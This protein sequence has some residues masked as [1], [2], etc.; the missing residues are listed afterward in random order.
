MTAPDDLKP[1]VHSVPF[2]HCHECGAYYCLPCG[3]GS[4][5]ITAEKELAAKDAKIAQ[6]DERIRQLTGLK[7]SERMYEAIKSRM[8]VTEGNMKAAQD[9]INWFLLE[10]DRLTGL[11]S[12]ERDKWGKLEIENKHLAT[13]IENVKRIV[14]RYEG[15]LKA[16][17]EE[18]GRLK[19]QVEVTKTL[20]NAQNALLEHLDS[21]AKVDGYPQ[22]QGSSFDPADYINW[23]KTEALK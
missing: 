1:C 7:F 5:R 3:K 23:L 12:S 4:D 11:L 10:I 15:E 16:E 13:E 14:E 9:S 8:E 21:L 20:W 2:E 19:G 6:M 18:N 22:D 17:R